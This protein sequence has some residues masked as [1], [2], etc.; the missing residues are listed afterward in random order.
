MNKKLLPV[1]LALLLATAAHAAYAGETIFQIRVGGVFPD[2]DGE[3]WNDTASTF[4]LD[5]KSD[6]DDGSIG[7]TLIRGF[8]NRVEAGIN[9]D[10]YE[11]EGVVSSV[12]G[13]VDGNGFP[14]FHD[15][16]LSMV[17]ATVDV[18]LLPFGRYRQRQGGRSVHQPVFYLGAGAGFTFWEYE[19]IGD[20]VDFS[21][22]SI[23]FDRFVDDG[24]AFETHVLAGLEL[25]LSDFAGLM[26][27]GRKSWVD[28]ELGGDFEGLGKIELGG[29]SAYVGASFKF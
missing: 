29:V 9:L 25:P 20:F 11:R 10:F 19:E 23:F 22:N 3:F 28:D 15:S 26:L 7:L 24:I 4:T 12:D 13:F 6:F 27:E 1:G 18:R 8:G 16:S 2:G 14:I 5:P 17:P 21:D